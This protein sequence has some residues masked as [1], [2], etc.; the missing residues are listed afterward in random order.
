MYIY[1]YIFFFFG[2]GINMF[3]LGKK[4]LP[5]GAGNFQ[6]LLGYG[7]IGFTSGEL[8]WIFPDPRSDT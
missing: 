3:L 5:L 7:S 2:G 1:I 8:S 4:L 6:P